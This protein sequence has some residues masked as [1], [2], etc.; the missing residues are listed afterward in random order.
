[1][2]QKLAGFLARVA[3]ND[4]FRKGVAG[5]AAGALIAT[6]SELAWPSAS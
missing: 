3:R 4:S 6:I 2:A 5:V 1:M